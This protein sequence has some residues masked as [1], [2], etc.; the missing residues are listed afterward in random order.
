MDEECSRKRRK[1]AKK[2]KL[3]ETIDILQLENQM[4]EKYKQLLWRKL[5][6]LKIEHEEL[7]CLQD[8]EN[9]EE[10]SVDEGMLKSFDGGKS[11]DFKFHD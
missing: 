1:Y 6:K 7:K 8:S 9:R 4:I 3:K 2:D 5:T 10:E 11:F